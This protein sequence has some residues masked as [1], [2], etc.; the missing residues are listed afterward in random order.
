MP[1]KNYARP[2]RTRAQ[3][4]A[5]PVAVWLNGDDA[6]DLLCPSGYT[7]LSKN[8][9]V[10]KCVHHIADR[11]SSMTIRLMENTENGDRRLK[12]GLSRKVDIEPSRTMSR[13]NF[14][15][16]L[17]TDL[18]IYGNAVAFPQ[19]G[20][21]GTLD[22]LQYWKQSGTTYQETSDGYVIRRGGAVFEPEEL[23]HF[24]LN[25]DEDKP[26]CGQGFTPLVRQEVQNLVQANTT[27]TAFLQSKWKPSLIISI[28]SDDV[29]L[30]NEADRRKI[31]GSYTRTTEIG[32]PWLIPAGELDVKTVQPLTLNDLAIQDS[33]TLDKR[34][35][36]AAFGVPS[37]L[38]GV[39]TF[40]REEY[41]AFIAS[42]ILP[43]AQILQQELTRKL[44]YSPDWYFTFSPES[45]MQYSLAEL[46]SMS[47]EL[48]SI[49]MI[50]RNEGRAKF[51][52]TPVEGLDEYITLEN[53]IP[54][55]RLGDQKKLKG[56]QD[57]K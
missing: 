31:L 54:V 5:D 27:K 28:T 22:D 45:L 17:V 29:E 37:F 16:R 7:P 43:I 32:E 52:Y 34:A 55:S 19:V 49:G 14:I 40:N 41:N 18:C 6:R 9:D 57:E 8:G 42:V 12:N 20:H 1:P 3:P 48:V 47:T 53:Y 44:V 21:A 46:T 39:G 2:P 33:I 23:L 36:A 30:Q 26:F 56:A 11:V 50:N 13:K 38:L 25:P 4:R 51:G 15:Y 10:R 24:V 35:I